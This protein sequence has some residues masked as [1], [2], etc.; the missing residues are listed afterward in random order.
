MLLEHGQTLASEVCR[1]LQ[2]YCKRIEVAGSIRRKKEFVR[3]ID[4]VLIPSD[5]WNLNF[6]IA[7][8]GR[9]PVKGSK[10]QRV[11][12]KGAQVDLYITSEETWATLFLI[13]TGSKENNIR[14]CAA[15]QKKGW[16][17]HANGDGLFNVNRRR[18]AGDTEE[19]IYTALGLPYQ[20]PEARI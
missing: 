16:K 9:V 18:I 20:Q 8:L 7:S 6:E 11:Y 4:I 3:D 10:V 2:P 13:R 5:P 12:Y 1:K 14:L 17:L 15:A 19:S